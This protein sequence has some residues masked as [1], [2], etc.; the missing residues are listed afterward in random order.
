MST[1]E[2][3]VNLQKSRAA[4]K[5]KRVSRV[6]MDIGD[7]LGKLIIKSLE[8]NHAGNFLMYNCECKCGGLVTLSY[9]EIKKR[10]SQNKGC[11]G[12][13]CDVA[14]G[15]DSILVNMDEC[16]R[17]QFRRMLVHTPDKVCNDW[18]GLGTD[19]D[20]YSAY[21]N[22][23]EHMVEL[24]A[25]K[26]NG[27][28]MPYRLF[29]KGMYEPGNVDIGNKDRMKGKRGEQLFVYEQNLLS[30]KEASEILGCD[31]EEILTLQEALIDDEDIYESLI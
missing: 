11:L 25:T 21:E 13:M 23:Y 30:V 5:S 20:L 26:E 28:W 17:D 24:G 12:P 9:A 4:R 14:E 16:L 3:I 8:T 19:L 18:G 2:F 29:P 7:V 15:E 27:Y 31:V 22:F 1:V 10:K 6:S